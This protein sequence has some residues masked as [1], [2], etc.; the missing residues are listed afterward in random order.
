VQAAAAVC[1]ARVEGAQI[2]S[3]AFTFR[4]GAVRGGDYS[5]DIGTAGSSTLVLQTVLPPLMR[6]SAPSRVRIRGGTHNRGSPPFDFLQRAFARQLR[7][8]GAD[9]DF[10]LASHGF[11]PRGGGEIRASI[12]PSALGALDLTTRGA[13]VRGFAEAY[14]AALPGDIAQR[15]LQV[16]G[17]QLGWGRE[18]LHLRALPNDSGPGN[19]VTVTLEFENVTEVFTG[20]GERGVRAED[21]ALTAAREAAAYRAASAPVGEHLADQLLLPM[22]LGKGGRFLATVATEHLRTNA[23]VVQQFTGRRVRFEPG[24]EGMLVEMGSGPNC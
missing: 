19:A 6:A 3:R 18:Q 21:V 17:R 22:A 7:V 9:V 14:V 11:Y 5:F 4:P 15:E 23:R 20:F 24:P 13:T 8:M 2:G 12:T 10:T 16:I 1:D